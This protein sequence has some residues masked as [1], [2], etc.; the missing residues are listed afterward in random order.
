MQPPQE[1]AFLPFA[2]L[3]KTGSCYTVTPEGTPPAERS[4]CPSSP[5]ASPLE[6]GWGSDPTRPISRTQMYPQKTLTSR[7]PFLKHEQ[8][9]VICTNLQPNLKKSNSVCVP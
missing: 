9:Y 4:L 6:P 3:L 8:F 7:F 2:F 1:S 5:P